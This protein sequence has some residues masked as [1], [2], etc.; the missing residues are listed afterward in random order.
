[1]AKLFIHK[2]DNDSTLFELTTGSVSIGRDPSNDIV[3]EDRAI[4]KKHALITVQQQLNDKMRVQIADLHSTNGTYVN[5]KKIT[6]HVLNDHDEIQ[7]GT[8]RLIFSET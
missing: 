3:L 4:S 6:Y 5:K 8:K 2:N 7:I 1:M